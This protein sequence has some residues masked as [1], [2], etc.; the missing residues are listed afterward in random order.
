MK[1]FIKHSFLISK[2]HNILPYSSFSFT[3]LTNQIVESK[4]LFQNKREKNNDIISV[5]EK[6]NLIN[7]YNKL[8]EQHFISEMPFTDLKQYTDLLETIELAENYTDTRNGLLVLNDLLTYQYDFLLE[9]HPDLFLH[10]IYKVSQK[11]CG[12]FKMY[13]LV[14]EKVLKSTSKIDLSY[15]VKLCYIFA[16]AN[17][18]SALF[19]RRISEEVM[20]RKV[21]SLNKEDFI[22]LYNAMS[23]YDLN[24]K[25]F[26]IIME[27]A[28]KEMF[29]IGK[30]YFIER[31]I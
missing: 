12:H 8:F 7:N 15:L 11:E 21:S 29:N 27:K 28:N 9:N 31:R 14:E 1:Y 23:V 20:K 19:Y 5:N 6:N 13:F 26:W 4:P 16:L 17:Q 24:N 25:M 30:E 3:N 18:G 2:I 22:L 10:I